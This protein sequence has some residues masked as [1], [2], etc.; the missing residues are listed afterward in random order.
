MTCVQ[1]MLTFAGVVTAVNVE[2][3]DWSQT[4]TA[5]VGGYYITI[6]SSRVQHYVLDNAGRVL[7]HPCLCPTMYH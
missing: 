5:A 2:E 7:A 6:V 4:Q 1:Y 3:P